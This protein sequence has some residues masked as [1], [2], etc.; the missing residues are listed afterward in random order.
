MLR[1][2]KIFKLTINVDRECPPYLAAPATSAA[3]QPAD[4]RRIPQQINHDKIQRNATQ[5]K[6]LQIISISCSINC[7]VYN[8]LRLLFDILNKTIERKEMRRDNKH[9]L[10]TKIPTDKTQ[11]MYA[12]PKSSLRK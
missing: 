7:M 10:R 3:A 8:L 4:H 1:R 11:K 2:V 9:S 6:P 12:E 5:T